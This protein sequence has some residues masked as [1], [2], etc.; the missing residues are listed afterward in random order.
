MAADGSIVVDTRIDNS[1]ASRGAAQF[2]RQVAGLKNAVT[3]AGRSM[4]DSTGGYLQGLNKA[5]AATRGLAKDQTALTRGIAKTEAAIQ[6]MEARQEAMRRKHE[7][8][9]EA[10]V[11][12]AM[13][14]FQQDMGASP[15]LLPWEDEAQAMEQYAEDMNLVAQKASEAYGEIEDKA[16]FQSLQIDIDMARERLAGLQA[17]LAQMGAAGAA[18]GA[19]EASG[20][21]GKGFPWTSSSSRRKSALSQKLSWI[22]WRTL[23]KRYFGEKR[24]YSR[25][26]SSSVKLKVTFP[27]RRMP[28]LSAR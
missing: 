13:D 5:S 19:S 3:S 11:G 16:S 17:E 14:K 10:A 21:A 4:A 28:L 26:S 15:E 1:G 25:R 22:H 23:A 27:S 9:R 2:Q 24:G 7:I 18:G 8:G 20:C 12:K 6:R